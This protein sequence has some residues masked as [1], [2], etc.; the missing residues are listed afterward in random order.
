MN[1][2]KTTSSIETDNTITIAINDKYIVSSHLDGKIML[3]D[4]NFNFIR[5]IKTCNLLSFRSNINNKYIISVISNA[6]KEIVENGDDRIF[7]NNLNTTIKLYNFDGDDIINKTF[8][9][10]I[11]ACAISNNNIIVAFNVGEASRIFYTLAMSAYKL[12]NIN[13]NSNNLVNPYIFNRYR[14]FDRNDLEN[15]YLLNNF[16]L[17][18]MNFE[19]QK[20]IIDFSSDTL[21]DI[22]SC[23]ISDTNILSCVKDTC[24]LWDINGELVNKLNHDNIHNSNFIN[25]NIITISMVANNT[26]LCKLWNINGECIKN[27]EI[28]DIIRCCS[29]SNNINFISAT[30]NAK[31]LV[32]HSLVKWT[33][34][35]HK[36]YPEC[37]RDSVKILFELN[38]P[39][40]VI[41]NIAEKISVEYDDIYYLLNK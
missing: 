34:E 40:N 10:T 9:K 36:F 37:F 27:F 24:Y 38:L 22:N 41:I 26:N 25:N 28:S 5:N 29:I 23:N 8:D 15:V 21:N 11:S 2:I 31:T 14:L 20:D 6:N 18:N 17:Y 7:Y 33:I 13:Y 32:K 3:W 1:F 12:F 19:Y 39:Y 4:L 16:K 35:R 30:Q